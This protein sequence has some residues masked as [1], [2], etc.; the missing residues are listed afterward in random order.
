MIDI[1]QIKKIIAD[2]AGVFIAEAILKNV[3]TKMN[4]PFSDLGSKS[5]TEISDHVK[6]IIMPLCG[7]AAANQIQ[8]KILAMK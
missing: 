8:E 3:A 6:K 2:V 4:V 5:L 1:D 7:I